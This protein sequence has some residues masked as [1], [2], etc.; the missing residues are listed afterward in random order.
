MNTLY[1]K[2]DEIASKYNLSPCAK[3]GPH[4]DTNVAW[5]ETSDWPEEALAELARIAAKQFTPEGYYY[6][7]CES[8]NS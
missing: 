2:I 7:A 8:I 6:V 1:Q 3:P 4:H 5:I